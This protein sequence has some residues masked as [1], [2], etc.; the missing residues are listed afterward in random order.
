MEK[1]RFEF[2]LKIDDNVICQRYFLTNGGE[3]YGS[4][5]LDVYL[6]KFCNDFIEE[7]KIKNNKFRQNFSEYG[8][9]YSIELKCG[10]VVCYLQTIPGYHYHPSVRYNVDIRPKLKELLKDLKEL[11]LTE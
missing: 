2:I 11:V 4:H 1:T 6:N 8:E 3:F 7:L 9:H 5:E 10:D